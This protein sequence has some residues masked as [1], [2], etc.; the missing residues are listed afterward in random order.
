MRWEILGLFIEGNC[1]QGELG[2]PQNTKP[3]NMI[4]AEKFEVATLVTEKQRPHHQPFLLILS[5]KSKCKLSKSKFLLCT[6]LCS[7][8]FLDKFLTFLVLRRP[9]AAITKSVYPFR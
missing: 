2:V 8:V 1:K 6:S 9:E 7:C 5:Q 4:R 3:E